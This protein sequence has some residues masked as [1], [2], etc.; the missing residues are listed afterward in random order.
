MNIMH[1]KAGMVFIKKDISAGDPKVAQ[2]LE[3]YRN[4][5]SRLKIEVIDIPSKCMK[6]EVTKL[7]TKLNKMFPQY[8][9]SK[10]DDE[11][12]IS[13][14]S[15]D[16]LD[17]AKKKL[18]EDLHAATVT[19]LDE[20]KVDISEGRTLTLKKANMVEQEVDVIVNSTNSHLHHTPGTLG[21]DINNASGGRV[22][23]HSDSI[24]RNRQM[25]LLEVGDVIVTDAG[26]S[27][28]CSHVIHAVGPRSLVKFRTVMQH[29]VERILKEAQELNA[30]SVAIPAIRA[31][32]AGMDASYVADS[33]LN[34]LLNF[35]YPANSSLIS[36]IR[37]VILDPAVYSYF[38]RY[39]KKNNPNETGGGSE[40]MQFPMQ[41]YI[42]YSA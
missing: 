4:I 27:L 6:S 12:K 38:F 37:V 11:V 28:N 36:D 19:I 21:G 3:E 26:G 30:K 34:T 39:L 14:L 17:E 7:V 31:G 35:N 1:A 18:L 2:F 29:V 9:F 42:Q 10:E 8:V 20:Y 33:I 15:E 22:Q 13:Y 32:N 5:E 41:W 40:G 16:H 25:D 23:E 24:L